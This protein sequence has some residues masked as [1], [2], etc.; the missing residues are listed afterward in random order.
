[1]ELSQR[2]MPKMDK[3]DSQSSPGLAKMGGRPNAIAAYPFITTKTTTMDQFPTTSCMP[4]LI[5][6]HQTAKTKYQVEYL[7]LTWKAP[8]MGYFGG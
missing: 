4:S 2:S 1:M 8:T 3:Y 6:L 5:F 7:L